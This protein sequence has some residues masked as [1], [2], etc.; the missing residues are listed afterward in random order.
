MSR[1]VWF[2]LLAGFIP[3]LSHAAIPPASASCA[4]WQRELSFAQ[5]VQQH[6]AAAFRRHLA[7]DAVFEVTSAKPARGATTIAQNWA[8]IIAGTSVHLD[9]YP[10]QVVTSQ[11]G[12]LAYSSGPYLVDNAAP[13]AKSRYTLGHYATVWRRG[14]DGSWL[15]AFDGGDEGRPASAEDAAAFAGGRKTTCQAD[16][17]S[18]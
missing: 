14:T 4:V 2:L 15:V 10:V 17:A 16:A 13:K 9:W 11:D 1:H 8:P 7:D 6:D 5:S 18:R 12:K 3:L